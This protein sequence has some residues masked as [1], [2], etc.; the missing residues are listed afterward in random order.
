MINIE[1][2][3]DKLVKLV[4]KEKKIEMSEAAKQLGVSTAIVQEWADF[5]EDEGLVDT[6]YSLSK[7]F[8]IEKR[9]T[10]GEVQKKE[11]EYENKKEAFTRKVD[12]ILHQLET[13]TAD[14]ENI[15][16]QYYA[17]KDQ[18][19]DQIDAIKDE[20]EQ[21]RHY[22]ELK[23][24]IDGDILKQ[25]VEYQKTLDEIHTRVVAE[26]RRYTK[27]VE[28]IDAEKAKL[29]SERSEFTDIKRE[30]DE[31]QKRIEALQD[32]IKGVTIRLA[33]QAQGMGMHEERMKKLYDLEE[34]LRAE[35]VE[36][37]EKEIEPLLKVS[38]DQEARIGRI[39]DEIVTKIKERRQKVLSV[40]M[41]SQEITKRF[42]AFFEKRSRTEE[43]IKELEKAKME[44]KEELN[45]LILKAKAYDLAAK[46]SDTNAHI[47]Q[48]EGKIKSFDDKKSV[49]TQKLEKLKQIILGKDAGIS[50]KPEEKKDDSKKKDT[51]KKE[52]TKKSKTK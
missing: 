42:E 31:L 24:N 46:N 1:T 26:E 52:S 15:K 19:G 50:K 36:R 51:V 5:L 4:A 33:T 8:L 14:F 44:M 6:Q 7:T 12:T 20:L 35:I 10:K 41:E 34:K 25:K 3:V 11:K 17:L 9:L 39:Q 29:H 30:E 18:I 23:K 2:G 43:V 13:E 49:F 40:D 27:I 21:L 38:K 32:I 47:K 28:D 22:E 37:K 16:T 48:L 45:G